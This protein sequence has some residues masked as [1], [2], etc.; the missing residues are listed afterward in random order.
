MLPI[1]DRAM[2]E[3][4]MEWLRRQ[5]T[6]GSQLIDRAVLSMGYKP[7]AIVEAYPQGV[8]AEMPFECVVEPEPL[9]T[10]GAIAFGAAQ[11][12]ITET[13]LAMNGDILCDFSCQQ[14]LETHRRNH[15]SATIALTEA[16]D[17]SRFGVVET[18]ASGLVE[19]FIEKPSPDESPSKWINAGIYILEPSVLADLPEGQNI[20]I[21]RE[22]F[23]R[24]AAEGL[25]YAHQFRGE[26]IDA[27]TPEAFL[28]AQF[29]KAG[30]A[31]PQDDCEP[32]QIY[33]HPEA[34]V[35]SQAAVS[36]SVLMA[37][38][39][40]QDN[41][42]VERSVLLPGC[43]IETGAAVRDS[44]VGRAAVVGHDAVVENLSVVSGTVGA[45]QRLNGSRYS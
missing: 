19:R 40:V 27:G 24:L 30:L 26:W 35:A 10:A 12:Q 33:R 25:L 18:T 23:P 17:P 38:V 42:T 34:V 43:V 15:A 37:G 9:G 32:S 28:R 21:E 11:A 8:C 4:I 44:I 45:G 5:Q 13:F 3:H 31:A 1:A 39:Q 14:L 29:S 36:H 20:S 41:A 16:A 2:L 7:D 22:V 6:Q